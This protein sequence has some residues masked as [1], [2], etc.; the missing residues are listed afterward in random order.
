MKVEVLAEGFI[1]KRELGSETALAGGSRAVITANGGRRTVESLG[2]SKV[3]FG[4]TSEIHVPLQDRLVALFQ[5]S[6]SCMVFPF[7]LISPVR[8]FGRM[9]LR[10]LNKMNCFGP[11]RIMVGGP[12]L[13]RT[14]FPV[15]SWALLRPLEHS[16]L[17]RRA[18]GWPAIHL[19][20][21]LILE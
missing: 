20:T 10:V 11:Y 13:N 5:E 17:L 7:Q 9:R 12:G 14:I 6:C 8:P 19:T 16:V 3:R 18:A 2:R 15:R 21:L 1:T 4:H